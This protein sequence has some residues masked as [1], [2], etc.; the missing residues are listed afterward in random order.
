[1]PALLRYSFRR[2]L[3]QFYK[4]LKVIERIS[5][6]EENYLNL[7]NRLEQLDKRVLN[8]KISTLA[9]KEYHDLRAHINFARSRIEQSIDRLSRT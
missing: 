1:V 7:L 3:W 8:L 9:P 5:I 6:T 2:R 4:E